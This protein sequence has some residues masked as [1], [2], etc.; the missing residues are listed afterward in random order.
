M[1]NQRNAVVKTL[2]RNYVLQTI[3]QSSI[4]SY[5]F[6]KCFSLKFKVCS[7]LKFFQRQQYDKKKYSLLFRF[8]YQIYSNLIWH[9]GDTIYDFLMILFPLN[10][11]KKSSNW[12]IWHLAQLVESCSNCLKNGHFF[13]GGVRPSK[14]ESFFKRT[15]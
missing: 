7:T 10:F 12:I 8:L 15:L 11:W 4:R 14:T 6:S 13:L 1:S 3:V 2:G 5:L 9:D